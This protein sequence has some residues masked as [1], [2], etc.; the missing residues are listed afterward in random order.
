M[1][2]EAVIS[3]ESNGRGRC[4][5]TEALDLHKLGKLSCTRATFIEFNPRSQEWEVRSA[6]DNLLLY[7]HPSRSQCIAWEK[8]NLSPE[9]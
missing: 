8:Q 6:D 9:S 2:T 3:F 7:S 5:Y 4:L 1:H